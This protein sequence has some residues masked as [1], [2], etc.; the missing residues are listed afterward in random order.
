MASWE[1]TE[2]SKYMS[3]M[4]LQVFKQ[5]GKR[6]NY[7][8]IKRLAIINQEKSNQI[9]QQNEK[10][11]LSRQCNHNHL[12]TISWDKN[13]STQIYDVTSGTSDII[14]KA[15]NIQRFEVLRNQGMNLLYSQYNGSVM[16]HKP[17]LVHKLVTIGVK[18]KCLLL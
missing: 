10:I 4:H 13:V 17:N 7:G 16:K 18:P 6:D 9:R 12:A 14:N 3:P 5:N 1:N 11:I 8:I 2:I 15:G